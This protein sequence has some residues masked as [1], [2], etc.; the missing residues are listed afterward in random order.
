MALVSVIIPAF[1]QGQFI[2]QTIRSVLNQNLA[3]FEL[4]V[5]DDGSTDNTAQVVNGFNDPRVGYVYQKNRG[6][7]GARNTGIRSTQAPFLSFLDSDDLFLP[8]NL[9]LLVS[10]LQEK[11]D[12]GLAA[13]Q[14]IPIDENGNRVGRLF[15]NPISKDS[16]MFLLGNP[17]QV[18]SMMIRR[19]WQETAGY[20]DESLRSYE[21]WDLWLRMAKLGCP[22]TWV[23]RPVFLYRFHTAQMT[24]IGKQMTTAT[25]AVLDKLYQSEGIPSDWLAM[26]NQAYSMASLRAAANAYLTEDFDQ[27][28][29]YLSQA[30]NLYPK[31]SQDNGVSVAKQFRSWSDSPK[32]MD[33][34]RFLEQ[35]YNHLP[36]ELDHL[37]HQ[38]RKWL[39]EAAASLAFQAYANKHYRE[40]PG[41]VMKSWYYSWSNLTN[42]GLASILGKSVSN[43][44]RQKVIKR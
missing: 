28:K 16:S 8:Q 43:L 2:A 14:A 35:I 30:L 24:R 7:A 38:R 42:R 6:L 20:F 5:V 29:K 12:A 17:I 3:D 31:L 21:D 44:T 18:G 15:D 26:K 32:I 22:M 1:N 10:A 41:Y 13:G 9:E 27:A 34:L 39:A 37:Q 25:F 23:P 33:S 19:S 11:P 4:I 36:A 40:V